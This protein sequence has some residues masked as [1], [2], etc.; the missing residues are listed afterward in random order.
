[1]NVCIYEF[2]LDVVKDQDVIYV[3]EKNVML[4]HESPDVEEKQFEQDGYE[5]F[6]INNSTYVINMP[7][8][9]ESILYAM[10]FGC[11]LFEHPRDV[12]V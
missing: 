8:Y 5:Q 11:S 4:M 10:A 1:M 3:D 9:I 12:R 6:T 2:R 7:M